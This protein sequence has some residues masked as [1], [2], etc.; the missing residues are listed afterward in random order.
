[1]ELLG[2]LRFSS[3][4]NFICWSL[5]SSSWPKA[6]AYLL[7]EKKNPIMTLTYRFYTQG[8]KFNQNIYKR[9][10]PLLKEVLSQ[11]WDRSREHETSSNNQK[12]YLLATYLPLWQSLVWELLP[13]CFLVCLPG[14]QPGN[15]NDFLN[16]MYFIWRNHSLTRKAFMLRYL[17]V[18]SLFT[19]RIDEH[20]T[21]LVEKYRT[22]DVEDFCVANQDICIC[23]VPCE[24]LDV[25]DV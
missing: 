1:M 15:L 12:C 6:V 21:G 10:V 9:V 7:K 25:I 18:N 22:K 19:Y 4:N 16:F 8:C 23:Q 2:P 20:C 5:I 3:K 14:L 24:T 11:V 17:I 13:V